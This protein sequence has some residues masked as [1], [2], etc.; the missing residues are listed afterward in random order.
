MLEGKGKG[1]D[2]NGVTPS[3]AERR[4]HKRFIVEVRVRFRDVEGVDPSRWGRTRDLSLGGLHLLSKDR[5][6]EGS[7][8]A[9]E[10]HIQDETAPVLALGRVVWS[11][12]E[13]EGYASGVEFL[14]VSQEDRANLARLATY[15]RQKYGET[16]SR[17]S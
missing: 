4:R 1:V 10:I 5:V 2:E 6:P 15:F 12:Q 8:L 14:W 9:F 11:S 13:G 7:H 3:V 16:G 17:P